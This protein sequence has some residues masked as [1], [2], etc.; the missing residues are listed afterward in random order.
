MR[1]TL[2]ASVVGRM[3][4]FE[5]EYGT[6]DVNELLHSLFTEVETLRRVTGGG[7][8]PTAAGPQAAIALNTNRPN[9]GKAG[10]AATAQV[11]VTDLG[12]DVDELSGLLDT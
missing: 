6:D 5:V 9:P 12:I 2:K 4:P 8:V 1:I 3:Q 7:P 11:A 10:Q